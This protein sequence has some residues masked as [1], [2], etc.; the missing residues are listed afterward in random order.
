MRTGALHT[1]SNQSDDKV[2]LK[3]ATEEACPK[4]LGALYQKHKPFIEKYIAQRVSL[5]GEGRDLAHA[6]FLRLCQGKCRYSGQTDVRGYLCGI[7]KNV[8][9]EYFK[10]KG[11]HIQS[12]SAVEITH[13]GNPVITCSQEDPPFIL[14]KEEIRQAI[15]KLVVNLPPKSRQAIQLVYFEELALPQ[16]AQKAGCTS[17][18]FRARLYHGVARL[19]KALNFTK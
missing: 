8:L 9:R 1:E 7:A 10:S 2:L 6:V 14:H 15:R 19:S 12:I 18:V 17:K 13:A 4:A 5:N 16:A 3:R 11:R